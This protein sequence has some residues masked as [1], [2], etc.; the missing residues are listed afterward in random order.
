[1]SRV[2]LQH[3]WMFEEKL[4]R[5]PHKCSKTK[6]MCETD[7][8]VRLFSPRLFFSSS[9]FFSFFALNSLTVNSQYDNHKM[10]NIWSFSFWVVHTVYIYTFMYIHTYVLMYKKWVSPSPHLHSRVSVEQKKT[11]Q[12]R[13]SNEYL[14]TQS[15]K[16]LEYSMGWVTVSPKRPLAVVLN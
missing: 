14:K 4:L 8:L 16:I 12:I 3:G 11:R 10:L 9:S 13:K 7:L 1:M 5:V 6:L 15:T 2:E